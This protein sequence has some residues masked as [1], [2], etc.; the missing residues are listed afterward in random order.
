[1]SEQES[2]SDKTV[3]R[4]KLQ[5]VLYNTGCWFG[6]LIHTQVESL[7]LRWKSYQEEQ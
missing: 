4:I 7:L 2:Q 3:S 6:W 1:M 5:A